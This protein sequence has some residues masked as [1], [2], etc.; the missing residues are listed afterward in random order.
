MPSLFLQFGERCCYRCL[1]LSIPPRC[2]NDRCNEVSKLPVDPVAVARE[3]RKALALLTAVVSRD[4]L[5]LLQLGNPGKNGIDR[6]NLGGD[7][8]LFHDVSCMLDGTA[9]FDQPAP[10]RAP[11]PPFSHEQAGKVTHIPCMNGSPQV[12]AVDAVPFAPLPALRLI[13]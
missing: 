9:G 6:P 7:T 1:R 5:L 3:G 10:G 4:F 13:N 8:R 2:C 12:H 11:C